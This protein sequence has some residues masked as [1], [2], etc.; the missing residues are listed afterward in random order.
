MRPLPH[1]RGV[2]GLQPRPVRP[3]RR[4]HAHRQV[5]DET[6]RALLARRR[7]GIGVVGEFNQGAGGQRASHR[8]GHVQVLRPVP[9]QV[10]GPG[11]GDRRRGLRRAPRGRHTRRGQGEEH[12]GD[13]HRR[14]ARP[15]RRRG[16]VIRLHRHTNP[17]RTPRVHRARGRR[18]A[19]RGRHRRPLD[20]RP[21]HH[22]GRRHHRRAGS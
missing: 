17:G 19:Q 13:H 14:Q 3:R 10:H 2:P 4:S 15:R 18:A 8:G 21:P 12:Q 11:G 6:H 7:G 9:S 5:P 16:E 20:R 22:R 1:R